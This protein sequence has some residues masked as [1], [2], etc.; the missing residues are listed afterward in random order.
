MCANHQGFY[1]SSI[2]FVMYPDQCRSATIDAILK[3]IPFTLLEDSRNFALMQLK[4]L[5]SARHNEIQF[6]SGG[7]DKISPT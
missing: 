1:Q 3:G 2:P 5:W 7:V 4:N 6:H